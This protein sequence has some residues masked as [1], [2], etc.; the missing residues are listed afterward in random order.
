LLGKLVL[1]PAYQATLASCFAFLEDILN[2]VLL[3]SWLAKKKKKIAST[4][5]GTRRTENPNLEPHLPVGTG[6]PD[7]RVS[8][9]AGILTVQ[10]TSTCE[11]A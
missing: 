11:S 7:S 10:P 3:D 2:D 5:A 1:E 6:D 4:C 8:L 9:P